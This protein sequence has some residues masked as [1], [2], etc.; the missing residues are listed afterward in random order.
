MDRRPALLLPTGRFPHRPSASR[1]LAHSWM[2]LVGAGGPGSAHSPGQPPGRSQST[3]QREGATSLSLCQGQNADRHSGR[4]GWIK[5][6]PHPLGRGSAVRAHP[7]WGF[8]CSGI[9]QMRLPILAPGGVTLASS[10]LTPASPFM[11]HWGKLN[12][13][14][15]RRRL[16]KTLDAM[17]PNSTATS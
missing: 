6:C 5:R 17:P 2:G 8:R 7:V 9:R 3:A 1:P 11:S 12:P 10:L 15:G 13:L 16:I 4:R 14:Q